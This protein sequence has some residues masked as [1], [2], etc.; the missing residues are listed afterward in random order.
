MPCVG[1]F[2]H[3]PINMRVGPT[4]GSI[5]VIGDQLYNASLNYI[6]GRYNEPKNENAQEGKWHDECRTKAFSVAVAPKDLEL[7]KV[8]HVVP[9]VGLMGG[10]D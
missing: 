5:K 3:Y 10:E 4:E 7:V 6:D 2:G 1:K 9:A 8:S